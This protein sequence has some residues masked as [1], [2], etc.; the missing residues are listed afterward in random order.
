[1]DPLLGSIILFAGNFTPRG[2][3]ACN[4]QIL[5]IAQ[6]NALFALLGT[7]YGGD[8]MT[9]FA[10]PDLRGRVPIGFGQGNGLTNVALGEAAGAEKI[11]LTVAQ[12]PQHSHTLNGAG[13]D[14]NASDP[15]NAVMAKTG[16]LSNIYG[17]R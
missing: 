13:N 9:T 7:T 2:W 6:N 16:G 10:L 12:M 3:A 14:A 17:K 11:T 1:M 4:G 5:S 15:T 8:G